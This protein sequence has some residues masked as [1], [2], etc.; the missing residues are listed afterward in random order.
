M[1]AISIDTFFACSLM[2]ILALS[3]M[4]GTSKMLYPYINNVGDQNI[5]ERFREISRYILLNAGTPSDWGRNP[6]MMPEIFGLAKANAKGSYELDIDKVSRLNSENLYAF[7]YAQIFT[8][9][10]MSDVSF[11][12]EIKPIFEVSINLTATFNGT[13]ETVYQFEVL[14][15]D[16]GAAV[17]ADLKGYVIAKNYLEA[18]NVCASNGRA[19]LNVTLSNAVEGPALFVVFAKAKCDSQIA[20]FGVYA[21]ANNSSKPNSEGTF[22]RLS[23]LN[24]FLNASFVYPETVLSDAY[25]LTFDYNS[26]LTQ[27]A[28]GNQSATFQIPQFRDSSPTVL[29]VTGQNLTDFFAEWVA[30]PQ[31]PLQIGANF[32]NS[33]VISN[34]F[35]YIYTVTIDSGIYKCTFW[36]GGPKE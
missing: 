36:L 32:S 6:Q 21:F 30:Y 31:I 3:A 4:A 27:I 29:I 1:P 7:S 35:V 22:L 16:Q 28:S 34:V 12:I 15:E 19:S 8:A 18:T 20:S 24:Y 10:K 14:T 17:Q 25:A 11:K 33:L 26:T 13:D 5:R 2:V 9:L 23:P